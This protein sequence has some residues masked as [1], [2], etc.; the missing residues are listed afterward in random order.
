MDKCLL[1]LYAKMNLNNNLLIQNFPPKDGLHDRKN[2]GR[3]GI[4]SG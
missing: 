4:K 1:L 3:V 2:D